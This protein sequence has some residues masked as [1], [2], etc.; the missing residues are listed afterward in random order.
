[1][2]TQRR[3]AAS[4]PNLIRP[5]KILI[6]STFLRV[7]V[8]AMAVDSAGEVYSAEAQA[9]EF[10]GPNPG[11]DLGI[12]VDKLSAIC[13]LRKMIVLKAAQRSPAPPYAAS[14]RTTQA[15]YILLA[16]PRIPACPAL[17][18]GS[19]QHCPI[20]TPALTLRS[21]TPTS[22]R[23]TRSSSVHILAAQMGL[24]TQ[25]LSPL[26][27]PPTSM[28][29][30]PLR[31]PIF[32]MALLSVQDR[33]AVYVAKLNSTASALTFST[34][35]GGAN[36]FNGV[37][38][39]GLDPSHNVYI[40]G[41]TSQSSYP[42]TA[43]A[44]Q[45][46][47]A[48]DSDAFVTKLNTA[49]NALVFSTFLGGSGANGASGLHLNS[50]QMVFVTGSTNSANFPTAVNAFNRTLSPANTDAFVTA[51]QPDG[52]SLYYLTLLGSGQTTAASAI[53]VDPAWNAWV[54]GNTSAADFPTTPDA[55]Q[56]GLK[57]NSDGFIA[58][59]VIA[60]DLGVISPTAPA[61]IAK[62]QNLTYHLLIGNSG[63]DNSDNLV[64]TDTLAFGTSFVSSRFLG[65]TGPSSCTTPPQTQNGGTITC[66]WTGLPRTDTIDVTVTVKVNAASGTN[67]V[68]HFNVTAQT[69][70]L[71]QS[72]NSVSS[73]THVQ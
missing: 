48:G 4:S 43:G 17:P 39:I 24:M 70:D 5:G 50:A 8:E 55:F 2:T 31:L 14:S 32:R 45:T 1:M 54:V 69:Q 27:L 72:N 57:G 53:W 60:A 42:I 67:L 62:G 23:L 12:D 28:W 52:K 73:T 30:A 71:N 65:G 11:F 21:S 56:P 36:S 64:I 46:T 13:M 34:L 33:R 47:F 10:P 66:K 44:F 22:R 29:P 25:T 20:P 41:T 58:K 63:P 9:D 49:G 68:N 51:L 16:Q 35:L 40:A 61:T 37:S 59:I 38:A 26:I 19:S 3:E 15:M 7:Q 6:Y 18:A